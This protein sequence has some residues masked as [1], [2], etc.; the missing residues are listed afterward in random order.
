VESTR[1]YLACI[2]GTRHVIFERTG[3][4]G[5]VTRP[6]RFA[7]LVCDFVEEHVAGKAPAGATDDPRAAP[8]SKLQPRAAS[9]QRTATDD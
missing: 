1:E 6:D 8:G 5:V 3:H 2:P 9:Q 7:D 4:L